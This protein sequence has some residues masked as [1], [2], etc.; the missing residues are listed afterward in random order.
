[1][2][3]VYYSAT[4]T[5]PDVVC[6]AHYD[7][8][9]L[10]SVAYS[11]VKAPADSICGE[12]SY[13]GLP[14]TPDDLSPEDQA[15]FLIENDAAFHMT[16]AARDALTEDELEPGATFQPFNPLY[17]RACLKPLPTYRVHRDVCSGA[18]LDAP[19]AAF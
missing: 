10:K 2:F 11:T 14:L 19:D 17:C 5:T 12:C 8:L 13:D 4:D 15:I 18:C 3:I 16:D 1:M 7:Q 6:T 9:G